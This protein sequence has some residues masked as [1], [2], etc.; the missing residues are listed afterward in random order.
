MI[1]TQHS[2]TVK[3]KPTDTD[4]E[5]RK[6]GGL[7]SHVPWSACSHGQQ[8]VWFLGGIG[9]S[10]KLVTN[11]VHLYF[12]SITPVVLELAANDHFGARTCGIH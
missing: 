6:K 4:K 5:G 12:E 10:E 2:L 9:I 1:P 11:F 7:V 3:A 8:I